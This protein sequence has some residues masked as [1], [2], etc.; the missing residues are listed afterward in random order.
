M[1]QAAVSFS[2][3][4]E[5]SEVFIARNLLDAAVVA[6]V[7]LRPSGWQSFLDGVFELPQK[8]LVS[9]RAVL[10]VVLHRGKGGHSQLHVYRQSC[11]TCSASPGAVMGL[12][13]HHF[14]SKLSENCLSAGAADCV[15]VAVHCNLG[16]APLL[17]RPGAGEQDGLLQAHSA[18]CCAHAL[19]RLSEF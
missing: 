4:W 9:P 18:T 8:P 12:L 13:I 3:Y 6:S 2:F 15:T 7:L 5:G 1:A 17:T 16:Y 19:M 11:V 10:F 14:C